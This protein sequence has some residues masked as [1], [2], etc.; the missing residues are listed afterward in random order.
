MENNP[1]HAPPNPK[2]LV[3]P[4]SRA[5]VPQQRRSPKRVLTLGPQHRSVRADFYPLATLSLND[6]FQRVP[7]DR[8]DTTQSALVLGTASPPHMP[9][10]RLREIVNQ[11]SEGLANH[12]QEGLLPGGT[13]RSAAE[14]TEDEILRYLLKEM[15]PFTCSKVANFFVNVHKFSP[16]SCPLPRLGAFKRR[17]DLDPELFV[18]HDGET[19][20]RLSERQAS[21][22]D[23]FIEE[24]GC[25]VYLDEVPGILKGI[26]GE[27]HDAELSPFD[28]TF[29]VA[30]ASDFS[31][32]ARDTIRQTLGIGSK[33]T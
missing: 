15:S 27:V 4:S 33:Q 8:I 7:P 14:Q 32:P 6:A 18:K 20:L 2:F 19:R 23:R 16:P 17:F 10:S 5:L 3:D 21:A 22:W 30:S 28:V 1:L 24:E 25:R 29:G 12:F 31:P 26:N 9:T 13:G 11:T